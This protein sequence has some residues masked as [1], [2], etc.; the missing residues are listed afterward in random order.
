MHTF[1][2]LVTDPS[3]LSTRARTYLADPDRRLLLSIASGWEMAI[4]TAVGKL[5]LSIPLDELLLDAPARALLEW[6]PVRPS[7]LLGVAG[8]PHHHRDPFD[9]LIVAQA[10]AEGVPVVGAD[11]ALDAY[12]VSRIW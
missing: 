3:R 5:P 6:L 2:W 1:I 10:L 11:P 7:H 4:K 9:R 8:L 12:G